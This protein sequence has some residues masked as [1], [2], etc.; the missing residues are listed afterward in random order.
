MIDSPSGLPA[1]AEGISRM[2]GFAMG[3]RL[4]LKSQRGPLQ[5]APEGQ[6]R[7]PRPG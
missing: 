6:S 1:A 5:A 3:G 4:Q 7:T 2:K